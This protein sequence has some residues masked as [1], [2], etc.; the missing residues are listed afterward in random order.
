MID[1]IFWKIKIQNI[2]LASTSRRRSFGNMA[3]K[4]LPE[5][6]Q[7]H[8]SLKC[9]VYNFGVLLIELVNGSRFTFDRGKI[10]KFIQ[11]A[12]NIHVEVDGFQQ[13]FNVIIKI[14]LWRLTTMKRNYFCKFPLNA[15]R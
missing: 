7:S 14:Q 10:H 4:I 5:S 15:S 1:Y 2:A 13:I 9:D 8:V 11:W 12:Q 6:K 3:L